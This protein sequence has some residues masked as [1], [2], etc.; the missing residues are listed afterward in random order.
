MLRLETAQED[1]NDFRD[2]FVVRRS[3]QWY[4]RREQL[5]RDLGNDHAEKGACTGAYVVRPEP[6]TLDLAREVCCNELTCPVDDPAA[7]GVGRLGP[8]DDLRR[9]EP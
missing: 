1:S 6:S 5:S 9:D 8:P 7:E 4:C 3:P 2:V